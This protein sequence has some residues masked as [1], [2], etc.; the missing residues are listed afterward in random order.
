MV[1]DIK[2]FVKAPSEELPY[3]ADFTDEL[4]ATGNSISSVLWV[5][6]S[7]LSD[8]LSNSV[9]TLADISANY[10]LSPSPTYVLGGTSISGGKAIVKIGGGTLDNKYI[11]ECRMIDSAGL[12]YARRFRLS[13]EHKSE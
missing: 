11:V 1:F 12:K 10:G 4:A 9:I 5:I 2:T 8:S 3:T 6:P 13:I 7:S